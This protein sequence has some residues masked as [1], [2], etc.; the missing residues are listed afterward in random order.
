MSQNDN[1]FRRDPPRLLLA[2]GVIVIGVA[3][4]Q[5]ASG[6]SDGSEAGPG[7][8]SSTTEAVAWDPDALDGGW[9]TVELPGRAPLERVAIVDSA[10]YATGWNAAEARSELWRSNNGREW[11]LVS[12][13]SGAFAGAVINDLISFNGSVV[14]VGARQVTGSPDGGVRPAVWLSTDGVEFV[15]LLDQQIGG[16]RA[17]GPVGSMATVALVSGRL[18]A[19]GWHGAGTVLG[20]G[21]ESRGAVWIS[22]DGSRW[23]PAFDGRG[24]LGPAGTA[25]HA[26]SARADGTVVA[27][28]QSGTSAAIWESAD[29]RQWHPV[30]GSGG[31]VFSGPGEWRATAVVA[32]PGGDVVLGRSLQ[33]GQNPVTRVW[34]NTGQR[35]DRLAIPELESVLLQSLDELRPGFIATGVRFLTDGREASGVWA[36]PNGADWSRVEV[37]GLAVEAAATRDAVAVPSGVVTVGKTY[38]QPAVWVRPRAGLAGEDVAA[39]SPLPPPAWATIFQEQEASQ[40]APT[41]LQVAGSRM[42]GFSDRRVLWSSADGRAW[43]PAEFDEIG[44]A[45]VDRVSQ[46]VATDSQ[47]VLI[48]AGAD[49]EVWIS[50]DG[51]RWSP[52]AKGPPCCIRAVF[53]RQDGSLRALGQDPADN[54]WFVAVSAVGATWDVA[55][56]LPDLEVPAVWASAHLGAV[57]LVWSSDGVTN[58][59]WSSTNGIEWTEVHVPDVIS[60]TS[61][62]PGSDRILVAAQT[63]EGVALYST[64]GVLW[65]SVDLG[66]IDRASASIASAARV[67]DGLAA[68]VSRPAR[69]PEVFQLLAG[70]SPRQI[71]LSS[72]RG[73]GGLWA[74]LVPDAPQLRIIGPAHGRMTVWE[75]VPAE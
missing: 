3:L 46:I 72:T 42:F 35:W 71:E 2:L 31:P 64:N 11:Q 74:E 43:V 32:G 66:P 70:V 65:E 18:V 14:A 21:A 19:A 67:G 54:G 7:Q 73:F 49:A 41:R 58:T 13:P 75:W 40:S 16:W 8:S 24:Q 39:G 23:E 47:Y 22:D 55:P 37:E 30:E 26:V 45:T 52:P 56:E 25:V 5:L 34:S 36:S 63:T 28:G 9:L 62:W 59:A 29:I 51:L 6:I 68:I 15:R 4:W 53:P 57:D 48:S 44:L 69:A 60:W 10:M 20:P 27:V 38:D 12:D 50:A 61:V 33:D 17:E 1:I